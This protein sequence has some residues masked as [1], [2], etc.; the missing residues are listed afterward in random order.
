MLAVLLL[1]GALRAFL[2]ALIGRSALAM[3]GLA[4]LLAVQDSTGSYTQAGFATAV[5]GIANVVAAPWRA[6]AVDR[7][8]QRTALTTMASGQAA[9][10][11]ALALIADAEGTAAVWFLVLSA[12]VGLTAPPLGA[13]MRMIWA[14]LTTAGDQRTK[15]FSIDAVCEELLFVGGPVIITA[16]IVAG[17]PG[18]GLW[19]T[20]AAVL[21]GTAAMTSSASSGALRG[22]GGGGTRGDRPLRR[23]GFARVLVVLLGVGGVLG[24]AEIAAP[25]VAAQHDAVPASG[26]LLAALAGGS[27]LGGV[28]YGQLKLKSGIAKRLFVLCVGMGLAAVF[29]S[30]LDTLV[31]FGAGLALLGLCL[32]P[33]LITGYLI[34][35]TIVPEAGRTEAS[36][37]INTSV[38]LGASLASAAAGVVI[39]DSG[40]WLALLLMGMIALALASA[41]PFTGLRGI[42]LS[43]VPAPDRCENG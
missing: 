30:Q 12:V 38:N 26:W 35:D 19:V 10:F 34:A 9:G 3:G 25:A 43:A 11:V 14:S 22:T 6:R 8:G 20:A 37:W 4:L 28:L 21:L 23:P 33:S 27:A 7:F 29:V 40:A 2:P 41:V 42:E 17:S 16:V 18:V 39:D 15:A 24:V 32:A 36:T 31:L 13:A 1:P 5:F